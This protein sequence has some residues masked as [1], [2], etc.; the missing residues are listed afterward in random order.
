M[1]LA[2]AKSIIGFAGRSSS[3]RAPRTA[4]S[5]VCTGGIRKHARGVGEASVG[6]LLLTVVS[7]ARTFFVAVFYRA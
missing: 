1:V 4:G 5:T 3:Q 6:Y 2:C 7:L